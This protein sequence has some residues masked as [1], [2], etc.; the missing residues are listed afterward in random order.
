MCRECVR[1]RLDQERRTRKKR[2][3]SFQAAIIATLKFWECLLHHFTDWE[4]EVKRQ[5]ELTVPVSG[6]LGGFSSLNVVVTAADQEVK[7]LPV[8]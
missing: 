2:N 7:L 8:S 4:T 6:D 5:S 3:P 1:V